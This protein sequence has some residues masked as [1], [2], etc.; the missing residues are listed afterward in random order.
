[1]LLR[2]AHQ[3][4]PNAGQPEVFTTKTCPLLLSQKMFHTKPP[5]GDQ[6]K[7]LDPC[8]ISPAWVEQHEGGGVHVTFLNTGRLPAAHASALQPPE[9][10]PLLSDAA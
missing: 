7:Y 6:P 9:G 1:V 2:Y 10:P 8:P 3:T 4:L 5:N